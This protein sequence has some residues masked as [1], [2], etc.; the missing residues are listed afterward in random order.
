MIFRLLL[1][2]P[3]LIRT[4]PL[5]AGNRQLVECSLCADSLPSG[6]LSIVTKFTIFKCLTLCHCFFNL[7]LIHVVYLTSL[8]LIIIYHTRGII[9]IGNIAQNFGIN[10]YKHLCK[11]SKQQIFK[12]S[13]QTTIRPASSKKAPSAARS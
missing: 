4:E 3:Y 7:C 5:S 8:S 2:D 1:C 10:N 12:Q 11:M 13:L 9:A 6:V